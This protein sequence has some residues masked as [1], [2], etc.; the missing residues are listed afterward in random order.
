MKIEKHG[1]RG[2]AGV[3][4]V[5]AAAGQLPKQPGVDRAEGQ[6]TG[7]GELAGIW[8]LTQNPG[9]FAGG[10][11]S[12]D[13]QAGALPNQIFVASRFEFLAKGGCPAILPDDRIV[14]GLSGGTVPD[15]GGLAL[16]C[17][18]DSSYVARFCTSLGQGFKGNRDLRCRDLF[19]IV[20]NPSR[21][22]KDLRELTLGHG[23]DGA[24]IVKHEGSGTCGAL[25]ES[26]NVRQEASCFPRTLTRISV[27]TKTAMHAE[28]AEC[29]NRKPQLRRVRPAAAQRQAPT[30]PEGRR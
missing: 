27:R 14:D 11:I 19:G 26:E 15:D 17:D 12:V 22:R 9:D 24:A 25:I 10:E 29:Q 21:L 23:S 8:Y 30:T 16:V 28:I 6:T 13:Q 1:A 4:D 20:L 5:Y 18:A 2:V 7:F 3:G